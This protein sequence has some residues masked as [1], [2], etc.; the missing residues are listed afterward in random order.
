MS[1]DA[2][3]ASVGVKPTTLGWW[4][5]RLRTMTMEATPE[6]MEFLDVVVDDDEDGALPPDFELAVGPV[7]V[8]V[9]LGFHAGELRRLLAVLC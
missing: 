6:A 3:A 5:W 8:H 4:R 1:R 2:Y 9:P 7:R